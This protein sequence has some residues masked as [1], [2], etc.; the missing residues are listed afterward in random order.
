MKRFSCP[1]LAA[2]FGVGACAA[3]HGTTEATAVARDGDV[4]AARRLIADG[5]VVLD[6]RTPAEHAGGALPGAQ[7]IPVQ[8]LPQRLP[9]IEA[10]VGGDKSKPIVI[11]CASGRRAG[12]AKE[13]LTANGY[14]HVVNAGGYGDLAGR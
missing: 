14:T 5:A 7:L 10:L 2:L 13:M 6:V 4:A 3:P 8:D 1:I 9:D 12:K 11:Y